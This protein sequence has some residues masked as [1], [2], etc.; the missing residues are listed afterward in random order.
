[1]RIA[2]VR[3]AASKKS[4]AGGKKFTA[5]QI[6][7][8]LK[9]VAERLHADRTLSLGDAFNEAGVSSPLVL[10]STQHIRVK[11]LVQWLREHLFEENGAS[12][13]SYFGGDL[14]TTAAADRLATDLV[15]LSLFS[16]NQLIVVYEADKMKAPAQKVIAEALPRATS[17]VLLILS[18]EAISQRAALLQ[19]ASAKGTVVELAELSGPTLERWIEKEVA[20]VGI[21]SGIT[22][23]AKQLLI[24]CYG[25][26]VSHLAPEIE[27]LSLLVVPGEQISR[28]L[29]EALSLRSPEVTSFELVKQLAAK[30]PLSSVA[31][32]NDLLLQGLHP[33]QV[34]AFLS[35]AFRIMLA[36][37]E[38]SG[39]AVHPE[40]SNPWFQRQLGTSAS[41]FTL[42]ELK[43]A[44]N[45]LTQLDFQLK[46]SGLP[47]SLN[48]SVA[49]QEIAARAA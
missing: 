22:P 29:V 28:T 8:K 5:D 41:A 33:L 42:R 12:F 48:L 23:D 10:L 2:E 25:G 16:K 17:S 36:H 24:R 34:N 7:Q 39:A 45:R 11:R 9:P 46:D 14:S 40:L 20:R 38:R 1:M 18:A 13:S 19:E 26:D 4:T 37:R 49:I 21:A 43:S 15:S 35:R 31:L 47:P 27:K 30:S 44:I 3:M 6:L 32:V